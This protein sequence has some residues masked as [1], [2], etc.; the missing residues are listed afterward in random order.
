MKWGRLTILIGLGLVIACGP[1]GPGDER[2]TY[3]LYV[4]PENPGAPPY[5]IIPVILDSCEP[6]RIAFVNDQGRE[7]GVILDSV[8]CAGEHLVMFS[9]VRSVVDTGETPETTF[10]W[11]DSIESSLYF[12][13]LRTPTATRIDNIMWTR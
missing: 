6:V 5:P 11:L 7:L 13:R 4:V 1:P 9:G 2:P 12:Y 3:E 8:M 10:V